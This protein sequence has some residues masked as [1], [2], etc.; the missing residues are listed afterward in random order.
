MRMHPIGVK[1]KPMAR[2]VVSR[3]KN[4]TFSKLSMDWCGK[5]E[6]TPQSDN[7]DLIKGGEQGLIKL[8]IANKTG[9]R[10]GAPIGENMRN[11]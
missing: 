9:F 3:K 5:I 7:D 6:T 8:C 4:T 11:L 2:A 1:V 10:S